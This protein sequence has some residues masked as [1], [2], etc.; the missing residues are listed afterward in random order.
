MTEQLMHIILPD[1]M[2]YVILLGTVV[3]I[4]V[5][6]MQLHCHLT[7]LLAVETFVHLT[8]TTLTQEAEQL[9]FS[10]AWPATV[11]TGLQSAI[12]RVLLFVK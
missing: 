8:E 11:A 10:N 3:P 9:V 12:S 5:E 7:Q 1:C 4:A 2:L 6:L